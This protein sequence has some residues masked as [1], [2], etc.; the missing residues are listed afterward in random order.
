ML[1]GYLTG[2]A[3][4]S[5]G[6]SQPN[7]SANLS[8]LARVII[9]FLIQTELLLNVIEAAVNNQT[10]TRGTKQEAPWPCVC[11]AAQ[12]CP[13]LCN[14]MDCSPPGLSVP[15]AKPKVNS[16]QIVYQGQPL[17]DRAGRHRSKV[18][19][20]GPRRGIQYTEVHH[21]FHTLNNIIFHGIWEE[22]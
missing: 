3:I 8:P 10:R 6:W 5:W 18:D 14:T 2:A 22:T 16:P 13:P 21:F 12:S 11:L 1:G 9:S 17:R 20:E 4:F 15:R 19:L 7:T